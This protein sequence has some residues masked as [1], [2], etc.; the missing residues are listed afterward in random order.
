MTKED[1]EDF[2]I[3]AC[4]LTF[5]GK[6][7]CSLLKLLALPEKS[8]SL[9]YTTLE[10][11]LLEHVKCESFEC[12]QGGKFHKIIHQN[13]EN[14]TTLPR[15]HDPMSTQGYADNNSLRS[16]DAVHVSEHKFSKCLS[17]SKFHS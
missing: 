2:N 11:L 13:I 4:F 7:A 16:C 14:S 10:E 15:H 8:T 1:V 12:C 3:V 17:S 9:P 6:D 5:I